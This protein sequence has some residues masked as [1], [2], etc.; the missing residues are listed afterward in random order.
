MQDWDWVDLPFFI[1]VASMM[2][3]VAAAFTRALVPLLKNPFV[4]FVKLREE[5]SWIQNI[6]EMG[7]I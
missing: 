1:L 2:G 3:A 7:L 6:H 5:L 4:F